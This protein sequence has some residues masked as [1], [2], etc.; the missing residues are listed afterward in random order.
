MVL[1][2]D[3][4]AQQ[5]AVSTSSC[6][7]VNLPQVGACTLFPPGI[8]IHFE[9]CKFATNICDASGFETWPKTS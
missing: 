8:I 6:D 2:K 1:I 5:T 4:R 3:V 9:S 7:D